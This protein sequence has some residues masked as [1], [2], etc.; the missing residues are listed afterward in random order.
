MCC[1]VCNS[2]SVFEFLR[3]DKV[4][5]HQNLLVVDQE[6]ARKINSGT[7][8]ICCCRDCGFIYNQ[9]FSPD[10]LSYGDLYDNSQAYSDYFYSYL[11]DLA[12]YL[13]RD[14]KIVSS[15]I[16]EVG[17]GNGDFLRLLVADRGTHNVGY[18]FDPSYVGPSPDMDNRL[19]FEKRFY[20]P[21]CATLRADVV[22]CRH[23]IEHVPDPLALL[24]SVRRALVDSPGAKVFFE[25]PCV[26]WILEN[27]VIWDFFYEHC[28]L[29]STK[30]MTVAFQE[31]GFR[32]DT[33]RKVFGGQ[34]LWLEASPILEKS[35]EY[36]QDAKTVEKRVNEFASREKELQT[37]WRVRVQELAEQGKLALWGAGAKG[38]TFAQLVDP[39]C[40]YIDCIIDLNP[41]KQG[42]F[43]PGSGHP[44]VGVREAGRRCIR[45]A[46]L[47]N[48]NYHAENSLLIEREKLNI[49]LITS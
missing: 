32:V 15:R 12:A 49:T 13:L 4:S 29:F 9:C 18:G 42:K 20:G 41:N 7:L 47:M 14:K 35:V 31:A 21:D 36:I 5:V 33:V 2:T 11:Q 10:K 46:I 34:Y 40:R 28:S 38:V 6:Q 16:V 48:P 30:S 22:I 24:G 43:L 23:V 3:R 1:P 17:C 39:E 25:T 26:E 27:K 45:Q 19:F 8:G 37:A 44:I